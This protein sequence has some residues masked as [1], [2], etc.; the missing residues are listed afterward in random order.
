MYTHP[1]VRCKE[2]VE[3]PPP[4]IDPT[5]GE[6][7]ER[8]RKLE[9]LVDI[10]IGQIAR[11]EERIDQFQG[12]VNTRFQKIEEYLQTLGQ[13][14]GQLVEPHGESRRGANH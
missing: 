4:P 7:G 12:Q 10:R 8:V 9:E 1:L 6:L 5:M 14:I 2:R 3:D 13:L 11:L